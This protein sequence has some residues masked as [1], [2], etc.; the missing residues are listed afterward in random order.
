MT[1]RDNAPPPEG[2]VTPAKHCGVLCFD[3]ACPVCGDW[4]PP[5]NAVLGEN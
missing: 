2:W 4:M 5:R 3:L 1:T